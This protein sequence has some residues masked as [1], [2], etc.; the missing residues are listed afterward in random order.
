M[1]RNPIFTLSRL[2]LSRPRHWR[3]KLILY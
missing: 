1:P 3:A 2:P